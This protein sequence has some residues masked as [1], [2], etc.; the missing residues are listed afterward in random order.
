[1]SV[2]NSKSNAVTIGDASPPTPNQEV[3]PKFHGGR[4][5]ESVGF[6]AAANGDSIGST[7]RLARVHS[8]VRISSVLL[9]CTAITTGAADIGIYETAGNG[10]AV[11]NQTLFA[12]AQSL[13]AVL[14]NSDVVRESGTI[15]PDKIEQ[16]LWQLLGKASDPGR[17]YDVVLTLTAATTGAGTVALAVRFVDG[18]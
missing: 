15:T 8:S 3:G 11:V 4:L 10:G 1:M 7:Y 17:L 14:S 5:K 16:P 18:N 12:S 6:V 9:S 13:A 2:V